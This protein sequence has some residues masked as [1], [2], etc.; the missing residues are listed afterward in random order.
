VKLD[1]FVFLIKLEHSSHEAGEQ[2]SSKLVTSC[3]VRTFFSHNI[4]TFFC[5]II[6]YFCIKLGYCLSKPG[7]VFLMKL[8]HFSMKLE[9]FS[10]ELGIMFF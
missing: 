4:R 7:I 9:L 3:E 2:I 8:E 6:T 1:H 5:R 10:R